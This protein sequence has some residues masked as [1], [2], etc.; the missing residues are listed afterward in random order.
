MYPLPS[1]SHTCAPL[2]L[3]TKNGCPP[4]ARNARTGEFTPPGMYFNAS[5]NKVSDWVGEITLTK[6]AEPMVD[7]SH[8]LVSQTGGGGAAAPP[9]VAAVARPLNQDTASHFS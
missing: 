9:C 1:T 7:A 8:L 6:Y 4:T 2:A 3:L 5:A